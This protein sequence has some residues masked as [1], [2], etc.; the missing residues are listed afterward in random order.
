MKEKRRI[1]YNFSGRLAPSFTEQIPL[2]EKH[3]FHPQLNLGY[4]EV[5]DVFGGDRN[6]GVAVNLY[7]F[8]SVSGTFRS[9]REF[10]NTADSP[11]YLWDYRTADSFNNRHQSNSTIKVE[12]RLSPSTKV[13]VN[14]TMGNDLSNH[15]RSYEVRAFT[16]QTIGTTGNAGILPGFTDTVTRVRAAPG[17]NI[18]VSSVGP[19]NFYQRRRQGDVGLEHDL[20]PLQVD[21]T[22]YYSQSNRNEGS[23]QGGSLTNRI[24]NVGWI[25]D[26]TDS[27]H[28]PRF[29][30]TEGLDISNPANY[31]P[32]GNLSHNDR[33]TDYSVNDIRANA[34][35]ELAAQHSL[36][37]KAGFQ[38]RQQNI[39]QEAF[40]HR[41]NY[42]GTT[43]LPHDA[44]FVTFD[45]IKTGRQIPIWEGSTIINNHRPVDAA[46][47]REDVYFHYMN[48]YTADRDATETSTAGYAM[49]QGKAGRTGFLTGLRVERT[50]TE[51]A[52]FVRVRRPSSTADVTADPKGA[53]DRDYGNTYRVTKGSYTQPFPSAHLTHDIIPNL[54]ARLS[55]STS[56]GRP[57]MSNF[58]QTE[59][60]NENA[61]TLTVSNPSLLP[62]SAKNWDASLDYYFEPVG[63][64]SVGWFHKRIKDFIVNSVE[65]GQ[66][67]DGPDNGF[68]GEYVGFDQL[69][70]I[71]AGTAVV[72]GWEFSYQQQLTFLPG[73]LKGLSTNMSYTLLETRGDFGTETTLRTDQVQGFRPRTANFSLFWRHRNVSAQLLVNY[74]GRYLSIF[75][76]NNALMN[77]YQTKRT[78]LDVG[79]AYHLNPTVS[80][81]CNVANVFNEPQVFYRGFAERVQRILINGT[82]ITVGVGGRF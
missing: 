73:F 29:T 10:Q 14:T 23:G 36:Y 55:W 18:D 78:L 8:E 30:Q 71:N 31:R 20:G 46:L 63:S 11:A 74:H 3:R 12:Y 5:F 49:V 47:W 75:N 45:S 16:A 61:G 9:T 21:Y 13:F 32:T 65:V 66:V 76:A 41:W 48:R 7:Y 44:T 60:P 72:K 77:L 33:S 58:I 56:F 52:G 17:S 37:V 57:N 24:S 69:T 19:N 42:I 59:T 53:A 1:S 39:D 70:S 35:Y 15:S 27:E 25:L 80:L 22:F 64:L 51:G 54:K 43:A 62:Q 40:L 38:R 26:R 6:L 68:D 82:T 2:R 34:R 28:F 4:Q 79:I 50:E 81:T 67:G